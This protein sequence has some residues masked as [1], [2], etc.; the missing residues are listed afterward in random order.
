MK[1]RPVGRL[2]RFGMVRSVNEPPVQLVFAFGVGHA[3]HRLIRPLLFFPPWLVALSE[4]NQVV[5]RESK[6]RFCSLRVR[7]LSHFWTLAVSLQR[8]LGSLQETENKAR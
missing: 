6:R 4:C 8:C 2:N 3:E 7:P 5:V 1:K